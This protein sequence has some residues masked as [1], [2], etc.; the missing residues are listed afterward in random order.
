VLL[1]QD[2]RLIFGI[3]LSILFRR[4]ATQPVVGSDHSGLCLYYYPAA[5]RAIHSRILVEMFCNS[6]KKIAVLLLSRK[7]SIIEAMK[8]QLQTLADKRITR[9]VSLLRILSFS[10]TP[11]TITQYLVTQLSSDPT[12]YSHLAALYN[13]LLEKDLLRIVDPY[14]VVEIEHVAQQVRKG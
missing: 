4:L 14:S 5:S 9:P 11:L 13:T 1:N 12:I 8:R 10:L 7:N 3:H 6:L 2:S